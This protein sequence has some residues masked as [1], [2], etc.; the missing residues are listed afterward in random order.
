M[1]GRAAA[2][3]RS[4]VLCVKAQGR[5]LDGHPVGTATAEGETWP[6]LLCN[7]RWPPDERSSGN[8]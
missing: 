2:L 7:L 5:Q 8:K 4:R 3:M 1:A 6:K